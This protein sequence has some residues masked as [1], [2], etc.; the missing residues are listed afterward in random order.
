[1]VMGEKKMKDTKRDMSAEKMADVNESDRSESKVK[2]LSAQ[3][4]AWKSL[5]RTLLKRT[6]AFEIFVYVSFIRTVIFYNIRSSF[7]TDN[8]FF[9]KRI[10]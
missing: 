4:N 8:V 10:H 1:M 2:Y 7:G 3:S 5:I 9:L 6:G